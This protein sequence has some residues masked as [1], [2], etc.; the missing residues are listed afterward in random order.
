MKTVSIVLACSLALLTFACAGPPQPGAPKLTEL[1]STPTAARP[2]AAT[3]VPTPVPAAATIVPTPALV[4]ATAVPT[5]AAPPATATRSATPPGP[6]AA[7]SPAAVGQ[8]S[9]QWFGHSMFLLTTSTGTKILI[10]P[11]SPMGY[12][13]PASLP[14]DAVV[15]TH[16][17][18]D[19]T[20]IALAGT[21]PN[22]IRGLDGQE[23]AKVDTKVKDVS[24]RTVP[25]FHD[26]QQGAQRGKNS[27]FVFQAD[28]MTIVH[29]GDLGHAL[30]PEQ[31]KDIG[32]PDVLMIPVGGFFT[33]DGP[34][35]K[36]VAKALGAPAVVPMH[37]KTP[38]NASTW[39]GGPVEPFLDGQTNVQ[40]LGSNV[41][42]F[43]K[44]TL[45][46]TQT[47]VVMNFE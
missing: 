18:G 23:W 40:R 5:M 1:V 39:Q 22:V 15:A 31:V 11:M 36:E 16:N 28:G 44:D 29:L 24:V 46:K 41:F 27:V 30:T 2:A 34:T 9:L 21:N 6:V 35:A 42:K 10:D 38:K 47:V 43:S 45:P 37:Y 3:T 33:I 12:T 26:A 7:G 25:T 32:K 4:T 17:H 13:L 14:V 19:H 8:T 20:N